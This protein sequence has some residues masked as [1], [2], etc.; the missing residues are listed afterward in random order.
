MNT[1]LKVRDLVGARLTMSSSYITSRLLLEICQTEP[2][3]PS[4]VRIVLSRWTHRT[5]WMPVVLPWPFIVSGM[6]LPLEKKIRP[7]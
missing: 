4:N 6:P 3:P 7:T 2:S 5:F 1:M